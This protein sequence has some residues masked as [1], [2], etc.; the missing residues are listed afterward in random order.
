MSFEDLEKSSPGHWMYDVNDQLKRLVYA[1]S[2]KAFADGNAARDA[3]KTRPA[4]EARQIFIRETMLKNFGGL[5]A[6]DTP[7][8]ARIVGTVKGSGFRVEKIVFQSRPKNYVTASLYIPD[9]LSGRTGAVLFVCGHAREA[10]G[11][12]E[13]QTV[14]QY[15]AQAGLVALAMDPIGQGE[16]LSYFDPEKNA[17]TVEWGVREHD[18]AGAQC[19]PLGESMARYFLHDAMRAID[20]LQTRPEVDSARIGVTGNSGGGTQ[21]SLMM[22]CDPRIAAAAPGTFIMNRETYLAAGGGQDAEQI[23]PGFSQAGFDHADIILAMAPKPVCILAVTGD[24]F[25]I[26]GTRITYQRS[27]R[28]FELCGKPDNLQ[29]VEDV[30]NHAYTV[31]LAQAAAKFFCKHLRGAECS[32]DESKIRPVEDKTLWC[33]S[34]G[35]V[36]AEYSDA[37]FVHA[38]TARKV[39]ALEAQRRTQDPAA[40]VAWLRERVT[41]GRIPVELNPRYYG[42]NTFGDLAVETAMWWSQEGIFNCAHAFRDKALLGKKLPVTLAVWNEGTSVL[43]P[44]VPWIQAECKRGRAVVVLSVAGAGPL[45]PLTILHNADDPFGFLHK[46]STDLIFL[47]DD[48]ALLRTYDVLRALDMIAIWPDLD[49]SSIHGYGAGTQSLYL[50]LAAALDARIKKLQIVDGIGSFAAWTAAKHY[51]SKGVYNVIVRGILQ[52]VDLPELKLASGETI[53]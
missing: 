3:I 2:G 52:H 33:I 31:P 24:F 38:T 53:R 22:L 43:Q 36:Q 23:W 48:M 27:R 16:R 32:F 29:L 35:Q 4:L 26:E 50:H 21:T 9:S 17:S 20:Y 39:K 28:I 51:E 11:Y 7:L 25:P 12:P 34:A 8:D 37:E 44:H 45:K 30:A 19:L 15:L 5:P 47:G 46:L 14:C 1:R 18:Y 49:A 42:K 40:A 13:Y 6:S 10:K 41:G